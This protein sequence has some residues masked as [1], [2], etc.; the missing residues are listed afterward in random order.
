MHQVLDDDAPE[1]KD[2]VRL[3]LIARIA[4][5]FSQ[6]PSVVAR[7]LDSD[8]ERL[9]ITCLSFLSYAEA[10]GAEKRAK[11]ADDLKAWE[12]SK[13]MDDVIRNSFELRKEK[14]AAAKRGEE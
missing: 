11:S 10:Y 8:P 2:V 9:S 14:V 1:D 7:D 12:G 3:M 6:L 5:T 13:V 4:E